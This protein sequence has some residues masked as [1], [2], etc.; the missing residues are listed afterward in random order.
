MKIKD[1]Q[2]SVDIVDVI[3]KFVDVSKKGNSNVCLCPFHDDKNPSMHISKEK[4]I[5]KCFSCGASGNSITFVQNFNKFSFPETLKWFK[6]EFDL[7]IDIYETKIDENFKKFIAI[8]IEFNNF[9][10][11]NLRLSE[12][13]KKYLISRKFTPSIAKHFS[14]G[15]APLNGKTLINFLEKKGYKKIDIL[16]SGLASE[17]NNEIFSYFRN[18]LIIPIFDHQNN[19]VAFSGRLILPSEKYPKY[20]NSRDHKYFTKGDILFNFFNAYD[21]IKS[22]NYVFIVEGFMDVFS[23]YKIGILN[24]VAIMGTFISSKAINDLKKITSKIIMCLDNDSAGKLSTLK[25][26]KVFI[27]S[28]FEVEIIN[29]SNYKDIDELISSD[30]NANISLINKLSMEFHKWLLTKNKDNITSDRDKAELI[31]NVIEYIPEDKSLRIFALSYIAKELDTD[32]NI[33]KEIDKQFHYKK[34]LNHEVIEESN[35]E[36]L[37]KDKINKLMISIKK[38]Y[39]DLFSILL[40]DKKTSLNIW[41][42]IEEINISK[43]WSTIFKNI[44]QHIYDDNSTDDKQFINN[45]FSDKNTREYILNKLMFFK[46][47]KSISL[48]ID[49]YINQIKKNIIKHK[50]ETIKVDLDNSEILMKDFKKMIKISN[51]NIINDDDWRFFNLFLNL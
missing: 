38:S 5:Y 30:S 26:A 15:F 18:R 31:K 45:I 36:N 25:Y 19:L 43:K 41:P 24:V 1:I 28:G 16:N 42:S 50:I 44:Y 3:S 51:N 37:N 47:N 49:K 14:L 4:Q 46:S 7:P 33:V 39:M 34:S 21:D 32:V 2:N 27:R 48:L 12:D 22:L 8:N 23:M 35:F 40:V 20:L 10:E 13:A 29:F 11:Y 9:V 17:K 6:K